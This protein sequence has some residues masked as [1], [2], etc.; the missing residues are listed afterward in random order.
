VTAELNIHLVDPVST[1][2]LR[3]ELHKSHIHSRAAV[4][5]HL[6]IEQ[7]QKAKKMM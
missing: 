2:T 3:R 6:I 5:K 4:A 7:R 1:K